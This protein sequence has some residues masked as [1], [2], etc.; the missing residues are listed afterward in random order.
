[1][2]IIL[3]ESSDLFTEIMV[4]FLDKLYSDIQNRNKFF[5]RIKFYSTQR[6]I[7]RIISNILI[8]LIYRFNRSKYF[9]DFDNTRPQKY[10]VSLTSFPKRIG[11]VWIVIESILRQ[12]HKPD[13]IILWLSKEQ[14]KN[15]GSL[16]KALLNQQNRGL[17]I[18][19]VDDDFKSHKKYYYTLIEFP[20]EY[21]ITVDDDIIYPTTLIRKLVELNAIYPNSIVCHRA[22]KIKV[23]N[24]KVL[25]YSEWDQIKNFSGPNSS[26]FF[27]SGG[28]TLF[29]PRALH[30][31]VLNNAIFMKYC[32]SADDVWLNIMARLNTTTIVKSNYY[33]SLLPVFNFRNTNLHSINLG[34][35][36]NDDQLEIVR[37]YYLDHFGIDV[38]SVFLD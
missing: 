17:E 4:D 24:S 29:P 33:S 32:F 18:R 11:R 1:M 34:Q 19:Y 9:L 12:S 10:I 16:P 28:G 6:F 14:F 37:N 27:T 30:I 38:F 23:E 26:I 31:E 15:F 8:P 5:L 22:L 21:L 3:I 36:K 2:K 25:P 20:N 35:R 7:I 13:K